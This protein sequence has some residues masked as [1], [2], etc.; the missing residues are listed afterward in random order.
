[1]LKKTD[2]ECK[3]HFWNRVNDIGNHRP[4]LCRIWI[5]KPQPKYKGIN[6]L[7]YYRTDFLC[8]RYWIGKEYEG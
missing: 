2:H 4:N 6:G 1:M 7:R 8:I 5:R 3:T